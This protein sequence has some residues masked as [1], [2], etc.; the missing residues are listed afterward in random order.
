MTGQKSDKQ[1]ECTLADDACSDGEPVP[2]EPLAKT[3]T[4]VLGC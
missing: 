3:V 2:L 4:G 1:K